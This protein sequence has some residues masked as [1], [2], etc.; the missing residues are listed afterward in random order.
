MDYIEAECL[1]KLCILWMAEWLESM[2]LFS[3]V[4]ATEEK[5]QKANTPT[6]GTI[7]DCIRFQDG[8]RQRHPS[9]VS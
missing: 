6:I 4:Q 3:V 9:R 7:E 2:P 5:G 1:R 8:T